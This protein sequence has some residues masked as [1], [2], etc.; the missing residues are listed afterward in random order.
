MYGSNTGHN[1][2]TA[3]R[4]YTQKRLAPGRLVRIG[5]AAMYEKICLVGGGLQGLGDTL[6]E[7]FGAALT[8]AASDGSARAQAER[9]LDATSTGG[10][11]LVV[12]GARDGREAA[13]DSVGPTCERL[14]RRVHLDTLVVKDEAA[15]DQGGHILVCIDGSA[16]SYAG[17]QTAFTLAKKL[18][19]RV[20]AVGVYDPYLH[21]TL[22]NGIVTTLTKEAE[23][24]FKFK[25][26]E[27][28]HEEIID[29]GLA[30]IYQAHLE[31]ARQLADEAG[32][33]LK[34]TLLDG[35]A[36]EKILQLARRTKPWLLVM[37]RIGVHSD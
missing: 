29:T 23:A 2:S 6:R 15:A 16:Q 14:L 17:L 12:L 34:V 11:D 36:F 24:V 21:Y 37:G 20:E 18:G 4:A 13:D 26:Q 1:Q 25:D 32:V 5:S 9:I 31:V 22:F 33:E 10:D 19:K 28:L 35:K 27:K 3:A 8:R 30:K 7:A